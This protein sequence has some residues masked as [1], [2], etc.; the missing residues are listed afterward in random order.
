MALPYRVPAPARGGARW[1]A[2]GVAQFALCRQPRLSTLGDFSA[3]LVLADDASDVQGWM[4]QVRPSARKADGAPVPIDFL[5]PA[6]AEPIAQPYLMLPGIERLAGKQGALAYQQL[7]GG[8]GM[9]EA[10]IASEASQQR[11]SLLAYL[12]LAVVGAIGVGIA[13]AIGRRRA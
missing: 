8:A 4:E 11:L 6:E 3:I 2:R 13:A 12:A 1:S 7:R 5:L 10:Q 9:S